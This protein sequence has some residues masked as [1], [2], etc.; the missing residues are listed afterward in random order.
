MSL[1][2]KASQDCQRVCLHSKRGD[3]HVFASHW[4]TK[5]PAGNP[6]AFGESANAIDW[7]GT[8][9]SKQNKGRPHPARRSCPDLPAVDGKG[10][11][12][13]FAVSRVPRRLTIGDFETAIEHSSL[14][15][16]KRI[17][18]HADFCPRQIAVR[19]FRFSKGLVKRLRTLV[20][21]VKLNQHASHAFKSDTRLSIRL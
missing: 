19:D 9:S 4:P 12:E 10:Q 1:R 8:K 14:A 7:L 16:R 6:G 21:K 17:L 2:W 11:G 5:R 20:K 18:V 13:S 3:G 15:P